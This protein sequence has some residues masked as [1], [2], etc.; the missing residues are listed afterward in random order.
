MFKQTTIEALKFMRQLVPAYYRAAIDP[1]Y[2][3]K[4][5]KS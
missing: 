5:H 2:V 3:E 1:S 4:E